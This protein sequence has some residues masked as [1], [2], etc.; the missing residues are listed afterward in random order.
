[1]PFKSQNRS[2]YV[3]KWHSYIVPICCQFTFHPYSN[4]QSVLLIRF[5]PLTWN[6]SSKHCY[7]QESSWETVACII[8][9]LR[10]YVRR[11]NYVL[12]ILINLCNWFN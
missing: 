1:M 4:H 5:K 7:P 2:L 8:T 9:L 12:R 10:S 3:L 6:H 11:H